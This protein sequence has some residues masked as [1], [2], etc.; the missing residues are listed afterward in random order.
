MPM[1][2]LRQFI[3][4]AGLLLFHAAA[5]PSL[6]TESLTAPSLELSTNLTLPSTLSSTINASDNLRVLPSSYIIPAS[7]PPVILKFNPTSYVPIGYIG[8][9]QTVVFGLEGLV[10]DTI[11]SHGDIAIPEMG[12]HFVSDNVAISIL[13]HRSG[14]LD[15][16]NGIIATVLRGIWEIATLYY[17]CQ[18]N[19]DVYIGRQEE[20]Q[21]RGHVEVFLRSIPSETAR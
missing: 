18:L 11:R 14:S 4:F 15:M 21:H 7:N 12:T 8:L 20:P 9:T 2:L 16:T 10:Q 3:L 5:A 17:G 13:S 6:Q 19:L 1:F